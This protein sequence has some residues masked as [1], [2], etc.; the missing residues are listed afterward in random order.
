MSNIKC[1]INKVLWFA[2]SSHGKIYG[3]TLTPTHL[4]CFGEILGMFIY[5]NSGGN[6]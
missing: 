1:V 6:F 2:A 5:L 3:S 4:Q